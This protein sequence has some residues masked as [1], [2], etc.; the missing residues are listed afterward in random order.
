[1]KNGVKNIQA[2]AYNG[3]RTVLLKKRGFT[4]KLTRSF[5]AKTI[6]MI[7][8]FKINSSFFQNKKGRNE[9]QREETENFVKVRRDSTDSAFSSGSGRSPVSIFDY[10]SVSPM[11]PN[12]INTEVVCSKNS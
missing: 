10:F 9:N 2:A 7:N 5:R 1:M 8:S 4:L 11:F 6:Q 3:A 12:V